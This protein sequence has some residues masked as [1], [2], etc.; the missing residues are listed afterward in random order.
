MDA[1]ELH[2][3]R[4]RVVLCVFYHDETWFQRTVWSNSSDYSPPAPEGTRVPPCSV[5]LGT[6]RGMCGNR[7]TQISRLR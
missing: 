5:L 3:N 7:H 4:V 2:L 6:A 1:T